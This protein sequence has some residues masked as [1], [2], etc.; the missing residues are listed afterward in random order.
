MEH[1]E[2]ADNMEEV[3]HLSKLI[4]Q[5]DDL[6]LVL[7]RPNPTCEAIEKCGQWNVR[8]RKSRFPN[9]FCFET[10]RLDG[11]LWYLEIRWILTFVSTFTSLWIGFFFAPALW[12]NFIS[13]VGRWLQSM[14]RGDLISWIDNFLSMRLDLLDMHFQLP[15]NWDACPTRASEFKTSARTCC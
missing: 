9:S 3:M 8:Q 10:Y 6:L 15:S 7:P 13:K 4:S 14:P 1:V 12:V 11:W 2:I 5:V